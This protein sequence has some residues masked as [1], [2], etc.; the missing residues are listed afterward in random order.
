MED[1]DPEIMSKLEDLLRT[2][3]KPIVKDDDGPIDKSK[4]A[5]VPYMAKDDEWPICPN[6]KKPMQF[7]LQLNLADIPDPLK[8]RFGE[9]IIQMFYCTSSEP[10]CEVD[11]EG[12]FHFADCHH[13]RL[14]KP[15]DEGKVV[16]LPG[17][18]DLFPAKLITGW[19]PMD[20]FPNWEER[21]EEGLDLTEDEED[22]IA[23]IQLT[24]PGDKLWGWPHWVQSIEYPT[25]PKCG[26]TMQLVFQIDSEDN[27]PYMWGDVGCGHITQ[28]PEHKEILAFGWACG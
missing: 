5:G 13:L 9:G 19:E 20:D 28:C 24:K 25:C 1:I 4:F 16:D 2:A 27:L 15:M 3:Y 11:C 12:Y 23:D 21:Q 7:F 14:I 22:A 18:D 26:S 8:G 17:V 6:C 10:L